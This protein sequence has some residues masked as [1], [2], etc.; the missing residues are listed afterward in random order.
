M[1]CITVGFLRPPV[2][3]YRPGKWHFHAAQDSLSDGRLR[4][5]ITMD[6]CEARAADYNYEQI[7]QDDDNQ[8]QCYLS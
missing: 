5:D 3:D 6:A 8:L 4:I 7:Q 1:P 2:S